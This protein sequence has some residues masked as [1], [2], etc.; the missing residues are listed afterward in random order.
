MK[1]LIVLFIVLGSI[2]ASDIKTRVASQDIPDQGFDRGSMERRNNGRI[3]PYE[4]P[5]MR[6]NYP[7]SISRGS[8]QDGS[9]L[10]ASQRQRFLPQQ[11]YGYQRQVD[12]RI[13]NQM[14]EY[15]Q[16][17]HYPMESVEPQEQEQTAPATTMTIISPRTKR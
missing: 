15:R 4:D 9:E 6:D 7:A 1:K 12:Y 2:E 14:P 5:S 13:N 8:M 16:Y 11:P 3:N 10:T 17:Q